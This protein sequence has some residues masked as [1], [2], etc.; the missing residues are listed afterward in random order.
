ME[1]TVDA[2]LNRRLTVEQPK[3][4]FR[5]AVDTLL[6]A[7]AVQARTGEKALDLGCGV[8]GAML[9]LGVRV[10][11]L[12]VNG[13]EIQPEIAEICR[14]NVKR[15]HYEDRMEVT[16][17]DVT[18]LPGPLLFC[19]D[20]VMMNPPYHEAE[21]HDPSPDENKRI[22]NTAPGGDL[23][24]WITSA[25]RCL[26]MSGLLVMIHK[27]DRQDEILN[28][29]QPYFG[30]T[31]IMPLLPKKGEEPKRIVLRS[32]KGEGAKPIPCRPM[33]LHRAEGGYTDEVDAI[34]RH[35]RPLDFV[36]L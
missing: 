5:V 10:P 8:G 12:V 32:R 26:K 35:G 22:A 3:K 4:G 16:T 24:I 27:A 17:G 33:I 25:A 31:E 6:L 7:A 18:F 9:A 36:M 23:E 19:Y 21:K 11:G 14:N 29:M 20:H 13:L 15:N 2:I 1:T 34:L 28:A 30:E